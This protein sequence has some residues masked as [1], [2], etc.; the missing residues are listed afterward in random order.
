MFTKRILVIFILEP[1]N[2]PPVPV[3][4]SFGLAAGCE[5]YPFPLDALQ[6]ELADL[7]LSELH[8]MW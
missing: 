7:V 4:D 2:K 3:I 5:F 1:R 8:A 6:Y